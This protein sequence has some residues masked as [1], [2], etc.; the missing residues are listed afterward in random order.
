MSK[1][2]AV[3]ALT[4]ICVIGNAAAG[5]AAP[6][7]Y[8]VT[9][10]TTALIGRSGPFWLNFQFNDGGGDAINSAILSNFDFG[11][12]AAIDEPIE[13]AGGAFG[14]LSSSVTLTDAGGSF[15]NSFTQ[16]FDPGAQLRFSLLLTTEVEPFGFPDQFSMGIAGLPTEFGDTFLLIDVNSTN[17][18][19]QAFSSD[20]SSG[21][22]IGAPS[23]AAVPEP[24]SLALFGPGML[25]WVYRSRR[26]QY[27]GARRQVKTK[28][29]P[30]LD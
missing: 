30:L 5:R 9:L 12:G 21:V 24:A 18:L 28:E 25:L 10:D 8:D 2:L 4:T 23:I 17:P 16:A 27:K 26:R 22:D 20:P 13:L 14:N 1:C 19:I 7:L 3:I 29:T 6:I 11:G 15:F